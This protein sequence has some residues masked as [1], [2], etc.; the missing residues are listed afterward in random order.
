MFNH[1]IRHLSA[2]HHGELTP[3][4]KLRTEAHLR[5]CAKCRAA[6]EE[7]QFGAKL[8]GTL[9]VTNSPQTVG[10]IYDRPGARSAPLQP[11][12]VALAVALI[13]A[14]FVFYRFPHGPSWEV[15]GLPGTARLRPGEALQTD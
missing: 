13:I 15:T 14:L 2:Y 6:Y 12:V 7:I 11:I 5:T 4:E 1:V 3:D 8:A 9:S 10:A